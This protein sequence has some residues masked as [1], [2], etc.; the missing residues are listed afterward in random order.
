MNTSSLGLRSI[1]GAV[2][3]PV[4]V[5]ELVSSAPKLIVVGLVTGIVAGFSLALGNALATRYILGRRR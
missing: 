1:L 2:S 5:R 4:T 3:E